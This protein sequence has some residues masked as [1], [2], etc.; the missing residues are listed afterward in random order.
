MGRLLFW[1]LL[2]VSLQATTCRN[3]E[4]SGQLK[5]GSFFAELNGFRIHYEIRGTGPILMTLPNSWGINIGTLRNLYQGLE[6][7]LTLV[8]FDPR[9][10]GN[11]G[12]VRKE[13]DMGLGAVREDFDALRQHLGL[14]R[15]AVIG[16]SN[17]A[18]N[19]VYLA[20]EQ[21]ETLTRA[22]FLHGSA[23]FTTEDSEALARKRPGLLESYLAFQRQCQDETL[24]DGGKSKLLRAFWLNEMMPLT[25]AKPEEGKVFVRELFSD[26]TFSWRHVA[27]S[28]RETSLFDERNRLRLISVPSLIIHGTS[29]LITLQKAEELRHHIPNSRLVVLEESGHFSPLEQPKVFQDVVFEFLLSESPD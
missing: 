11:S 16:W 18:T 14:N 1:V 15:V 27:Y 22:I 17:G 20:S 6:D 25:C 28:E 21:P 8:Y 23:S 12:E 29:D 13:S 10:M 4:Q 9:G 19:L 24:S 3:Q 5:N 7:S 2:L 26:L